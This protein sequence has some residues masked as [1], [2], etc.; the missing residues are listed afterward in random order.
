MAKKTVKDVEVDSKR[1]LLRVDFNVPLDI[2]TGVIGDDNRIR[3]ALPTIKYIIDHK[4]R[5]IICSHLGRPKG[6]IV[7]SL[8]MAPIAKRLSQI[9]GLPV[10]TVPD[11]IGQ[12]V[13]NKVATL[14]KG[15]ILLLENLRFHPEEKANDPHFARKLARLADVYVDDAFGTAHRAH[16]STTGVT[17]YLPSVAGFLMDKELETMTNLLHQSEHP[18]ACILGGAKVNDKIGLLQNMLSKVDMLIVG[19]GMAATLLK[20]QG[21]G[22]GR[23]FIEEDKL[24]M[25]EELLQEAKNR[26]VPFF[27]PIDVMVVKEISDKAPTEIVSVMDIPRDYYIVDI[28]PQSIQLFC[29]E[30]KKCR[31]VMWN[32][33][34]GI[35]E[36]S[37]FAQGTR[38]IANLLATL[39][40]TTVIGGGSTAEIVQEMG[41]TDKMTH[42]ST[43][44]GASLQYLEGLTLPGVEVLLDK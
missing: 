15:D 7:E 2:N 30:L 5:V 22:V 43:G 44:G 41:L 36:I 23:S 42:V 8:R 16:A 29:S 32:G 39:N 31:T 38:S 10:S 34:M 3:S 20:T 25:A 35:Y 24:N 4:A 27:L 17:K 40:A 26:M 19:G 13:E 12:E 11:C 33:P 28:G 18:F 1:V 9:I 14:K 6:K 37:Q 21:Y